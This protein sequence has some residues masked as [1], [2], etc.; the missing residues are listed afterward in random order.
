VKPLHAKC[1]YLG[2]F[3]DAQAGKTGPTFKTARYTDWLFVSFVNFG[4][5]CFKM[6]MGGLPRVGAQ[7]MPCGGDILPG[8]GCFR[9]AV[10]NE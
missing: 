6:F 10:P 4:A 3:L 1:P 8:L 2:G 7:Q 9:G 5:T